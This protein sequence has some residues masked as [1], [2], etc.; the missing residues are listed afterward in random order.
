LHQAQ[1]RALDEMATRHIRH[2]RSLGLDERAQRIAHA[3]HLAPIALAH[4]M[5]HDVPRSPY[6]LYLALQLLESARRRL[7]QAHTV[8]P[9]TP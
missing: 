8:T 6:A 3:T 2:Y 9:L 7:R 5:R 1:L 4:A